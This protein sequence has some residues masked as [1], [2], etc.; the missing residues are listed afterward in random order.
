MAIGAYDATPIEMAGAWT[1]F[2][3]QGVHVQPSFVSLVKEA[4]REGSPRSETEYEAGARSARRLPR[5][6]HARRGDAHR[7]RGR[8]PR[9]R[10]HRA[11]G[12]QDRYDPTNGWFA[13]FTSDLLCIV[14]VGFDDNRKL[15]LEGAHSALPIWT[16][17]MKRAILL[18]RYADAKPF[19]APNGVV[20]VTI[21]PE[22]GMPASP[23]CPTQAPEV[24]IA[25]T[26]PV[27]TCPL[28]GG[29]GDRTTVSGWDT[30]SHDNPQNPQSPP[31]LQALPPR[32][33]NGS[34]RRR[35]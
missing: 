29:R 19:E 23:Q 31:S 3:N 34:Q 18:R 10:F 32:R 25:G 35:R 5:G 11:R 17:F 16:E 26:E 2:A 21:D 15:D 9:P 7:N 4:E 20:T 24:F 14:W 12:R 13:G 1:I 6:Q 28:H 8:R 22:S 30:P 33:D 27:G